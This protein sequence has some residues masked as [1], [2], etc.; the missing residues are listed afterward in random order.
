MKTICAVARNEYKYIEDWV[1]YHALLGFD[2]ITVYDHG[3]NGDFRH[4]K[5]TLIPF[6]PHTR[7]PQTEAYTD[8]LAHND[9]DWCAFID[10]DEFI[11]GDLSI[12]DKIKNY[13]GVR[14]YEKLYGDDGKI[15]PEEGP[16]Y[17]RIKQEVKEKLLHSKLIVRKGNW[18]IDSPH[19]FR[20]CQNICNSRMEPVKVGKSMEEYSDKLFDN[21][22]IRHYRTKTLSEF[23]EQ[24][25]NLPRVFMPDKVRTTEYYFRINEMTP[26]KREFLDKINNNEVLSWKNS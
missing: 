23:C 8:Y 7:C 21:L 13:D 17:S 18:I 25:L 26:E 2:K 24:K 6:K 4:D 1:K 20:N 11:T 5:L 12:L 14:L 3:N 9:F 16:V 10:I 22:Y 19:V 15:Y